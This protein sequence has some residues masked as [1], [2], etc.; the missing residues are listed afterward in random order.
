[1]TADDFRAIA[2]HSA[3]FAA[4]LALVLRPAVLAGPDDPCLE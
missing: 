3:V 4:I 2:V 1:M